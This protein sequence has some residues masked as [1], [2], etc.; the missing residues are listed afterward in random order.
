MINYYPLI[1]D[2]DHDD[3]DENE[4][5]HH[6]WRNDSELSKGNKN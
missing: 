1:G 5:M 6:P 3:E 4:L 2:D